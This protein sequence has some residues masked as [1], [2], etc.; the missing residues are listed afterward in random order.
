MTEHDLK[1]RAN[2]I[3]E[4]LRDCND[5]ATIEPIAKAENGYLRD[6]FKIN[7]LGTQLSSNGYYRLIRSIP[8]VD[9]LNAYQIQKFDKQGR[10]VEN[11]LEHLFFKYCG[12]TEEE[13]AE[14]NTTTRILTRL[15]GESAAIVPLDYL[16]AIRET[17]RD[18]TP[19][20]VCA[21]LIAATGR[22]PHEIVCRAKFE[23]AGE[24]A[25]SFSGQGKKRGSEPYFTI[26]TLL[27][28]QEILKAFESFRSSWELQGIVTHCLAVSE[29]VESQNEE[30]DKLTNKLINR[31]VARAFSA[32][33]QPRPGEST[34]NCKALRAAYVALVVKRDKG[35]EAMGQQ[36]LFA[37]RQLGHFIDDSPSDKDLAN[38]VT[39]VGYSDFKILGEVPLMPAQANMPPTETRTE[40]ATV[41]PLETMITPTA[42][43][44]P[45]TRLSC[46]E[47]DANQV[48]LWASQWGC[49]QAE[50][51]AKIIESYRQSTGED[52]TVK[53]TSLENKAQ[54]LHAQMMS[55]VEKLAAEKLE[56]KEKE[57]AR[58]VKREEAAQAKQAVAD[59]KPKKGV[60]ILDYSHFGFHQLFD[61][62]LKAKGVTQERILRTVAAIM[63]YN[64]QF[65][66]A[67]SYD[68]K[69]QIGNLAVRQLSGCNGQ[70]VTAWF[71][72]G[73]N[74]A[75]VDAHNERH[76]FGKYHNRKWKS[77]DD[78]KEECAPFYL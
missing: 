31:Q 58:A 51:L 64:D 61:P 19:W 40:T 59:S 13:W 17:M 78:I 14:R 2:N 43:K 71:A 27:P 35:E 50:A 18:S 11:K 44:I 69:W 20:P 23:L 41:T 22:R 16:T 37:A 34:I 76:N 73:E 25:L 24:Y 12:L 46:L 33:I 42:N 39:T 47:T 55:L 60:Q 57:E 32:F 5:P 68:R 65:P 77:A 3:Y 62:K 38:L 9:G 49:T 63:R 26:A 52:M 56:R 75:L 29:E 30:I 66:D 15:D 54:V 1:K 28:A 74:K 67:E 53:I 45:K 4:Q 7:S 8:L 72:N 21:A 70:S 6:R 10:V 36:M 48:K